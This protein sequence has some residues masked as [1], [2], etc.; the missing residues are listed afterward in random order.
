MTCVVALGKVRAMKLYRFAYSCYARFVQAAIGLAGAACEVVDVPYGDRDDLATITG[1]WIQVPVVVTD[2]G[3][4]LT[5]SRRIM[6]TLCATDAR[7]ASLVPAAD[8]AAVW[9]YVDWAQGALE[10]VA[11]RLASPKLARRFKRPFE[12]ALFT[13][14]KERRY[15]AGCVD[16]WERDA[17]ALAARF[18]ELLTPTLATLAARPFVCGDQ[19]TLADAALYGQVAMLEYGAPERLAALAAPF[20][21][22]KA[23]FD[24]RLGA[25]PYGRVASVHRPRAALDAALADRTGAPRTGAVEMIVARTAVD[26]RA[27][28]D[29]ARLTPEGGLAGDHWLGGNL[30]QQ[31]TLMDVRVA[32]AIAE[33]DDWELFGDNLIVDLDL[34]VGA[35]DPGDRLAV[36][37]GVVLEITA[38]PHLGCRKFMARVGP[39][40]L[41]WVNHKDIRHLRR[42]G[43]YAKVVAPGTVRVGDR[44]A[45]LGSAARA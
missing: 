18:E 30:D 41:R 29:E 19:P 15:G 40:A 26:A 8:A 13:F 27:R 34:H 16:A 6:T 22:W 21:A 11:F 28:L 1:G 3:T 23:R 33:R 20:H 37:D 24:E 7:F 12:R 10:D 9:A 14:I 31:L 2:D 44:L 32:A 39:D 45:V 36:G 25:P 38:Y 17:D 35:L 43:I 4:V 42:R 5:D